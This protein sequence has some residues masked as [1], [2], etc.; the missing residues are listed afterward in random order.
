MKITTLEINRFGRF[1]HCRITFPDTPFVIVYGENEAGKSTLMQFILNTWFGYPSGNSVKKW[2]DDTEEGKVGGSLL[3]T[4]NDGAHYRLER[5]LASHAPVL[6][7]N[8]SEKGAADSVLHGINRALYQDV[9][10]FDLD[11]LSGIEKKKPSE[12][13]HLL[14]GAGMV[15]SNELASLEQRLEKKTGELFKKSGRNPELNQLF[16]Q[17]EASGKSLNEWSKKMDG[18]RKLRRQAA[19]EQQNIESLEAQKRKVQDQFREWSVFTAVRPMIIGY[20]AMNKEISGLSSAADFPTD[21]QSRYDEGR[22]QIKAIVKEISGLKEQ[23]HLLDQSIA[24]SPVRQDWLKAEGDLTAWFHAALR[25]EQEQKDAERLERDRDAAKVQLSSLMHRLGTAWDE[26]TLRKASVTLSFAHQIER[27]TAAWKAR[28]S[29]RRQEEGEQRIRQKLMEQLKEKL[30]RYQQEGAY[31]KGTGRRQDVPKDQQQ[32]RRLY[33]I[34]PF[35]A[36]AATLVLSFLS[37]FFFSVPAAIPVFLTGGVLTWL[38]FREAAER[39]STN[40]PTAVGEPDHRREAEI[41]L[42]REQLAGASAACREK[43]ELLERLTADQ[44]EQEERVSRLLTANGYPDCTIEWADE[45]VSIVENARGLQDQID[46]MTRRLNALQARHHQFLEEKARLTDQLGL[47]EGDPEYIERCF[48][49]EKGNENARQKLKAKRDVYVKQR[50]VKVSRLESLKSEERAL[51]REAGTDRPDAFLEKA[52]QAGRRAKLIEMRDQRR[53]QMLEQSGGEERLRTFGKMLDDGTW[54]GRT[55][56]TFQSQLAELDEKI[57]SAQDALLHAR[58]ELSTL[59]ES[60]SY[61]EE[62]DNHQQLLTEANTLAREWMVY[63]TAQW[64]VETAKDRYRNQKLPRILHD[65][66]NFF[67]RITSG[68]YLSLEVDPSGG[69]IVGRNDGRHFRAEQLSRGSAEQLYL[70]LRLALADQV[71]PEEK[72]PIIIDEGLVNFDRNRTGQV[73]NILNQTATGRQVIL[74][75]C[76][77]AFLR[78]MPPESI[79]RLDR[80]DHNM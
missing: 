67:S 17:L 14:L 61:R 63:R 44:K 9:F 30:N 62:L 8:G 78:E 2:L 66:A 57:Q 43:K 31:D 24:A 68:T 65:A 11:G 10:C 76:H 49:R 58:S 73:L 55:E 33:L 15:G 77:E 7:K 16:K 27:E 22:K 18:Y 75:T 29:E 79:I 28:A 52:A 37:A 45:A 23:I 48:R 21:G 13:N 40:R 1:T 32:T 38:L 51:L 25:D 35:L 26:H 3:F 34:L 5:Y 41:S 53:I 47:P 42:V 69:F 56:N 36:L 80:S 4:G 50:A 71:G 74:F 60:T 46:E 64:A 12:L 6:L 19:L 20:R 70:S 72:L 39:R 54:T 59:E